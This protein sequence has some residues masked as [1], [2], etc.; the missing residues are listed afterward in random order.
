MPRVTAY[1]RPVSIE[2]AAAILAEPGT[3]KVIVGGGTAVNAGL[4]R[5]PVEVV[6]L[7]ALGLDAIGVEG[8]RMTIGAT[9]T[10]Q[11]FADHAATPPVLADLATREAPSTLRAAGTIGGLVATA[12]PESELFAGLLVHDMAVDTGPGEIITSVSIATGGTSAVARTVRTP[13]DR[14]I[15]AAVARR[16]DVTAQVAVTGVAATP[17]LVDDVA[18]LDPPGDFRG[19]P[20]YRTHLARVLVARAR[21]EVGA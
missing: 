5:E 1:H 10:L 13:G 8:G 17:I 20:G 14:P 21:E 11:A 4:D 7:Q 15:V 16:D 12:D 18:E 19:S 2:E 6:D 3:P 9:V